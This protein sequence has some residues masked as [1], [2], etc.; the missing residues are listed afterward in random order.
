[1]SLRTITILGIAALVIG[2]CASSRGP[3]DLVGDRPMDE[4]YADSI[5]GTSGAS[6]GIGKLGLAHVAGTPPPRFEE[7]SHPE[8]MYI[9]VDSVVSSD[10]YAQRLPTWIRVVTRPFRFTQHEAGETIIPL[11][12]G[13]TMPD[14]PVAGSDEHGEGL[15]VETSGTLPAYFVNE[16]RAQA[17][18]A[19]MPWSRP[20]KSGANGQGK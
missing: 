3:R 1:M 15:G 17:G 14:E 20:E 7:T 10:G 9:L 8:V 12:Q 18:M 11:R 2:G 4:V 19:V 16:I 13:A 5:G 6:S